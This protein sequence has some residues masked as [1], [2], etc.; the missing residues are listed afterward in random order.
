MMIFR[1]TVPFVRPLLGAMLIAAASCGP[2]DNTIALAPPPAADSIAFRISGANGPPSRARNVFGLSVVRC[3]TEVSQWTIAADGSTT[4]PDT[5]VF[6]RRVPGFDVRT[7]PQHLAPGCYEVLVSGA[8]PL[9]ILVAPDGA[10]KT[11]P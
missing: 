4:M 11:A 10:A 2:Y 1:A 8:K 6:G 3:G 7:P 9:R 5:V